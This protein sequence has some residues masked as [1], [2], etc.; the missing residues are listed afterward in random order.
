MPNPIHFI[1]ALALA[2]LV[3]AYNIRKGHYPRAMKLFVILFVLGQL[4]GYGLDMEVLKVTL[5]EEGKDVF[6]IVSLLMPLAVAFT[7]DYGMRK[8]GWS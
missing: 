3:A 4:A 7:L 6:S 1:L 8:L 2:V 5:V